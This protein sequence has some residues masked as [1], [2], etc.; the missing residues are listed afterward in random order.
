MHG[1]LRKA[2]HDAERRGEVVRNVATLIDAPRRSTAEMCPF[3]AEEAMRLLD[4]AKG[5]PLEPFYLVALTTGH[6][7]ANCKHSVGETST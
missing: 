6:A 1:T 4:A 3:T 7:S 5:D 2:L